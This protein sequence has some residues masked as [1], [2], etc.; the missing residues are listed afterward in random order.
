MRTN[1]TAY[2]DSRLREG[3]ER[4]G[5]AVH[6]RGRAR[7]SSAHGLVQMVEKQTLLHA[8]DF[9]ALHAFHPVHKEVMHARDTMDL[10][11]LR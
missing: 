6:A 11:L 8:Q 1:V 3:G 10:G 2:E 4:R 9:V 5:G 7:R